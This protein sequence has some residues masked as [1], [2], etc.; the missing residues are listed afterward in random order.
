MSFSREKGREAL[1]AGLFLSDNEERVAGS[2]LRSDAESSMG[3]MT[4]GAGRRL[5]WMWVAQGEDALS[6][7]DLLRPWLSAAR[8][9]QL[10]RVFR[11]DA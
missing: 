2:P 1:F 11:A 4:T 5:V 9:G 10:E 6:V 8:R 3:R 7:A